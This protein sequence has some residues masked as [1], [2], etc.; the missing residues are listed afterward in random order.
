M[1]YVADLDGH[2]DAPKVGHVYVSFGSLTSA[3]DDRPSAHVSYEE[4]VS[5]IEGSNQLPKFRGKTDEQMP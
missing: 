5:W 3:I 2:P 1:F 4:R